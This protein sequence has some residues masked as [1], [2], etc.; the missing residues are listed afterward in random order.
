MAITQKPIRFVSHGVEFDSREAAYRH[1]SLVN[2][3]EELEGAQ[4][5]FQRLLAESAITA[6]GHQFEFGLFVDYYHV[7]KP[8]S[9]MPRLR[10]FTYLCLSWT[11]RESIEKPDVIEIYD[12][13]DQKDVR[14]HF[15]PIPELYRTQEA[16]DKALRVAQRE[17]L[18]EQRQMIEGESRP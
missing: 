1:D 9:S 10:K 7:V 11:V 14:P 12:D 8:Y 16:A 2:A 13:H 4:R 3:R 18:E 17:W 15:V 5:T 6:D